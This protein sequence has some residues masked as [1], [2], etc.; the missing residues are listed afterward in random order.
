MTAWHFLVGA[1]V[2]NH[3]SIKVFEKAG[4]ARNA[5]RLRIF[6]DSAVV[7]GKKRDLQ[8]LRYR[9]EESAPS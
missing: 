4:F 9:L 7:R 6:E 3:G 2:G 8:I 5:A 1:F